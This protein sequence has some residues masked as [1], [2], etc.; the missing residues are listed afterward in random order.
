MHDPRYENDYLSLMM[1]LVGERYPFPLRMMSPVDDR[2][3]LLKTDCEIVLSS[4]VIRFKSRCF[5]LHQLEQQIYDIRSNL[6][7][8]AIID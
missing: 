1:P 6:G 3:V 4:S 2:V 7:I 5:R 8:R